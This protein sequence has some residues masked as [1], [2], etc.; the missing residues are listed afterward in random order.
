MVLSGLIQEHHESESLGEEAMF[1]VR[2]H[3]P[4]RRTGRLASS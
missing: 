3:K 4:E 1:T 2:Y